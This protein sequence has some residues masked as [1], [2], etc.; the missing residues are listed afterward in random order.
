MYRINVTNDNH[1]G[2][3][4]NSS[5]ILGLKLCQN[6]YIQQ[7]TNDVVPGKGG[8]LVAEH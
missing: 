6:V 4:K 8:C 2:G 7:I 1:N 5:C 3:E